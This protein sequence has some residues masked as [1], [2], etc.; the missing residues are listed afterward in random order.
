MITIEFLLTNK[1]LAFNNL[2]EVDM[3]LNKPK[4][5]DVFV[6]LWN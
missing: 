4:Q 5:I 1:I 3:P 6:P 2:S